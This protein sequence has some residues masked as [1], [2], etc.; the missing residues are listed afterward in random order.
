MAIFTVRPVR[1]HQNRNFFHHVLLKGR[2]EEV[3]LTLGLV[4]FPYQ[5]DLLY[6]FYENKPTYVWLTT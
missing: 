3:S 5:L 1:F 2:G 6:I 4:T